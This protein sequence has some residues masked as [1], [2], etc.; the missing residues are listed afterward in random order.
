[1]TLTKNFLQRELDFSK[2]SR[3]KLIIGVLAGLLFSFA[4][5][6][7]LYLI[8]E[9]FRILSVYEVYDFWVLTDK[10][11]HFYNL[12]FAYISAIIGQSITFTF[13]F[14][15]PKR[16]FKNQ[17]H[18]I[19]SI[20]ND[21]RA[22]NWYFLSWFSKLA[23]AFGI[24][25]GFTFR[26]GFY[27]FS[28]Y[29]DYNYMFILFV[30]VLFLQTWNTIRLTFRR[31]SLK[32]M[33]S[34]FVIISAI[35]FG[36]SK[37]NLIDYQV[38][39]SNYLQKNIH[40]NY[41]LELPEA[42]CYTSIEKRSL[43]ENIYLVESKQ[44]KNEPIIIVDNEIIAI[45][46][47]H[48]KIIE[49]QSMRNDYDIP[50]MTYRLHIHKSIK[51]E[52]V[53]KLKNELTKSGVSRV[54]YGVVPSNYTFDKR[55]YQDFSFSMRLP[56]WNADWIN[57]EAIYK[58]LNNIQN[59]IEIKHQANEC[60]INDS[61]VKK[62]QIKDCIKSIIQQNSDYIIKFHV[63]DEVDFSDYFKVLSSAKSAV[64]ELRNEY[65]VIKYSKQYDVL[66]DEKELEVR[67]K[68][69]FRILEITTEFKKRIENE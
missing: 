4:L 33:L 67:Q 52:F 39:Y 55:Y 36:L 6:S 68:F 43:T 48:E 45:D 1:M 56:N 42:D 20:I 7:L 18:R 25:F 51:M 22:L 30:V 19:T 23:V 50:F 28:L 64:N 61:L 44:T 60:L 26:R 34:S 31:N 69:P 63:N 32:W 58:D 62:H 29:P 14:E 15:R 47:L 27:V 59:I 5:Y 41:T 40:Y 53:N 37:V 16:F 49:R 13:W 11:V 35:S 21:Q 66:F 3:F 38:I 54:A 17:N 65:A 57:Q 24:M 46:K 2:I 12:I 10:E 9:V 8:R